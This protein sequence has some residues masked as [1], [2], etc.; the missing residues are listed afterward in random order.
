[1]PLDA[2][3]VAKH[4][5]SGVFVLRDMQNR[6]GPLCIAA[7]GLDGTEDHYVSHFATCPDADQHRKKKS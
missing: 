7:W 3:P 4:D 5:Q 6:E 2:K 1:M